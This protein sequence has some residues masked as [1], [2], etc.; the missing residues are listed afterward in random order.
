MWVGRATE[1]PA[2]VEQALRPGP[3]DPS[4]DIFYRILGRSCFFAEEYDAAAAWL[5]KSVQ[6]RPNLWYNPVYL[7][8]AYALSGKRDDAAKAL[9][10]LNRRFTDPVFTLAIV[11]RHENEAMPSNAPVMVAMRDRLHE[12][13][14]MV[15]MAEA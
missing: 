14:L 2:H 1:A 8:S 9:A 12:R 15:G 10:E 3:H 6:A 11:T 13:L 5:L 7:V 4:I